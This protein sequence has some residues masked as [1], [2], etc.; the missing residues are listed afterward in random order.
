MASLRATTAAVPTPPPGR[1]CRGLAAGSAFSAGYAW[2]D[3]PGI[4]PVPAAPDEYPRAWL[5]GRL[6]VVVACLGLARTARS[7]RRRSVVLCRGRHPELLFAPATAPRRRSR[8]GR[9]LRCEPSSPVQQVRG[10]SW[11]ATPNGAMTVRTVV[12]ARSYSNRGWPEGKRIIRSFGE[13]RTCAARHC[14][15]RLSR[16][17]PDD[18]CFVHR[19]QVP[20]HPVDRRWQG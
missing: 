13:N 2:R 10:S 16:Y 5:E 17:N 4:R 6:V 15:T 19:D 18:F 3:P 8:D 11:A 9:R 7:A 20:S 12:M 14:A 1:R